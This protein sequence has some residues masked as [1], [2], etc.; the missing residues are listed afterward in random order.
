M[1]SPSISDVAHEALATDGAHTIDAGLTLTLQS[2]Y[3]NVNIVALGEVPEQSGVIYVDANYGVSISAGGETGKAVLRLNG[4][5]GLPA[6]SL[7]GGL[8]GSIT[9]HAGAPGA[10][11]MIKLL[12]DPPSIVFQVGEVIVTIS[13]EGIVE[14]VAECT[15]ELTPE[16]HNLTAGETEENINVTGHDTEAPVE[17]EVKEGGEADAKVLTTDETAG[18]SNVD[19]GITMDV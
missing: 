3:G 17:G 4:A 6:I 5:E 19:A 2:Q 12:A 16:G 18:P 15:R 9:L 11:P 7:E 1:S 14:E 8:D 10:G 13:E